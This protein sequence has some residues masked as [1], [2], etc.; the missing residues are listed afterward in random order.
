MAEFNL[1][2][3]C[4]DS[5]AHS[6][7]HPCRARLRRAPRRGALVGTLPVNGVAD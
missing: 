2:Y 6:R 7:A 3:R 5:H 1:R 4:E